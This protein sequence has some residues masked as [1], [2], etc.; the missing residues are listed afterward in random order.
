MTPSREHE[1]AHATFIATL[2]E[3]IVMMF[4]IGVWLFV[5]AALP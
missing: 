1:I 3:G 4:F 2:A 5:W